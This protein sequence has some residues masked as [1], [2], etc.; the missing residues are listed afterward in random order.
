MSH[1][2][3]Y[4]LKIPATGHKLACEY[5]KVLHRDVSVGNILIVDLPDRE[6]PFVGFLHDFDYSSMLDSADAVDGQRNLDAVVELRLARIAGH[7]GTVRVG[8]VEV[9][10]RGDKRIGRARANIEAAQVAFA[11]LVGALEVVYI[12][13]GVNDLNTDRKGGKTGKS[14]VPMML[15]QFSLPVSR[16]E[17]TLR[18]SCG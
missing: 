8:E 14:Q 13:H 1:Y 7:A 5:T 2:I 11:A 9:L 10:P 16:Y 4:T 12:V 15:P 6:R 17:I 18:K 3:L